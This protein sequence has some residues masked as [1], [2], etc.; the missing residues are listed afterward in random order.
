MKVLSIDLDYIMSPSIEIYNGLFFDDNPSLRWRQLFDLSDFQEHHFYIDQ[1][2]LLFCYNTFLKSIK[3]CKNVSFGYEHDSILFDLKDCENI[4]IINI[5]HHDDFF[6]GD[7]EPHY[8]GFDREYQ[9][10]VN[11]DIIHEG[12][13]G[14]WLSSL[15][16]LKSFT[17]IGNSNSSNKKSVQKIYQYLPSF[18]NVEKENYQFDNYNFDYIFVCLSPQYV[19]KNH[20]HYFSMFISAY[21]E[22]T[23]N[24]AKIIT[25]KFETSI[26]H[27]KIND[28]ILHQRSNGR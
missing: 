16:K 28:E 27:L 7:Y 25:N 23:G 19:P 15:D 10:I 5:D 17:W 18:S 1:S 12:N 14:A 21:E 4:E 24:T 3:N 20:W 9:N 8:G 22:M 2:N 26:R 13:W 11:H 6:G